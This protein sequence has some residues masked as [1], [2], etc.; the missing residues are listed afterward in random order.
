MQGSIG[1]GGGRQFQKEP[2]DFRDSVTRIREKRI[3]VLRL[4]TEASDGFTHAT[5]ERD[6]RGAARLAGQQHDPAVRDYPV[7]HAGRREHAAGGDL[8]VP[9]GFEDEWPVQAH[10]QAGDRRFM[11]PD[12]KLWADVAGVPRPDPQH[13]SAISA[14]L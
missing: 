2:V 5:T 8:A 12:I 4:E 10:S 13:G 14:H 1:C 9:G 3:F 11:H 7:S 6:R